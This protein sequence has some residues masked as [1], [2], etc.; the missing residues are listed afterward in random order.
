MTCNFPQKL[1]LYKLSAIQKKWSGSKKSVFGKKS[2]QKWLNKINK[3]RL[4]ATEAPFFESPITQKQSIFEHNYVWHGKRQKELYFNFLFRS[5]YR[6][7]C[8][9]FLIRRQCRPDIFFC[10]GGSILCSL[11]QSYTTISTQ[12]YYYVYHFS[13]VNI[14][15]SKCC[16]L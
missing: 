4:F 7:W 5:C 3:Y 16:L 1:T 10:K 11:P 14:F 9:W 12:L 13:N 6:I 2:V 8:L 15:Q